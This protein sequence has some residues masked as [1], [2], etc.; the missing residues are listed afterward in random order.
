MQM[1]KEEIIRHYRQAKNKDDDIRILADLNLTTQDAIREILIEA[2]AMRRKYERKPRPEPAKVEIETQIEVD[3]TGDIYQRLETILGSV[4]H[5]AAE[6]VRE[7]AFN[8]L[9]AV[10][11]D[12]LRKR[13][14]M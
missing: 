5:G 8:L 2:G 12:Y 9:S 11:L 3:T 6:N 1:T 7:F 4:P 14:E 13:L 10:Y